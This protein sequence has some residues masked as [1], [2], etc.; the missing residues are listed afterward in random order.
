MDTYRPHLSVLS[1]RELEDFAVKAAVQL[2][3][4][5]QNREQDKQ[6]TSVLTGF[7]LGAVIVALGFVFG[8]RF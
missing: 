4:E 2:R 5:K 8:A 7:V 3:L 6:L 1:R